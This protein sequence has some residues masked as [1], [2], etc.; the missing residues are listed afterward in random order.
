MISFHVGETRFINISL[1]L[2]VDERKQNNF[3]STPNCSLDFIFLRQGE[4]I[5][6]QRFRTMQTI[7]NFII[8]L[9]K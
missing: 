4:E 8:Q 2:T 7:D 6:D 3:F 9:Q 1:S 5:S